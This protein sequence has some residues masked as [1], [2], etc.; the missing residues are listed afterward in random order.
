MSVPP[1]SVANGSGGAGILVP[2]VAGGRTV[3]TSINTSISDLTAGRIT[4]GMV[5]G[6]VLLLGGF[7]LWTRSQQGG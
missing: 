4:L 2:A 7:Y 6:S 3:G 1:L 5:A